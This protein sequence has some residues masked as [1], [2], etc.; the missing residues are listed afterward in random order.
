MLNKIMKN[1]LATLLL[2]M[3]VVGHAHQAEFSSSLLSKTDDGKYILQ[4][5]SSMTA[6]QGEI[7]YIYSQKAYKTAEEFKKLVIDYFTKNVSLIVNGTEVLQLK[8]PMVLLGHETKI[9]VEVIGIPAKINELTFTNTMFKDLSHNKM[10]LIML[11]DGFPKEQYILENENEQTIRLKLKEGTWVSSE[12]DELIM[13]NILYI[14]FFLILAMI[15]LIYVS[16]R[17]HKNFRK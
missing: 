17:D 16:Y 13:K 6:F 9:I 12:S 10:G 1:S 5:A 11:I 7:D 8:D 2:M 14:S 4:I 3:S 15:P